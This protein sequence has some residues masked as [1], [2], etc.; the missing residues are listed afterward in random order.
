MA[1]I[2]TLATARARQW[3][4]G[5][6]GGQWLEERRQ[7][8]GAELEVYAAVLGK[9][10]GGQFSFLLLQREDLFLDAAADDQLVDEYRFVL[11]ESVGAAGGAGVAGGGGDCG[12]SA[13][14]GR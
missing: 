1:T 9:D 5:D 7:V 8:V 4:A 10:A 3:R 13:V 14:F 11:P 12:Q 6:S 2:L